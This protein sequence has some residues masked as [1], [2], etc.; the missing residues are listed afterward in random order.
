[1]DRDGVRER[2]CIRAGYP[3]EE[4]VPLGQF[5]QIIRVVHDAYTDIPGVSQMLVQPPP[6]MTPRCQTVSQPLPVCRGKSLRP[7]PHSR[8][9]LWDKRTS[10]T[11]TSGYFFANSRTTS[12]ICLHGAAHGAQ[13]LMRETR[14]RSSES[15]LWKCSA[16]W[17]S[18]KLGGFVDITAC[19][20]V[21]QATREDER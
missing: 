9:K 11:R 2:G 4:G 19:Q 20:M 7:P 14:V 18:W 15:R 21:M 16:D 6:R 5:E 12:F 1:M 10:R 17:T 3:P 13:K 8:V